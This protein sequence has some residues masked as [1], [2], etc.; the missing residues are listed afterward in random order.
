MLYELHEF[1]QAT[2]APLLVW[3]QA[4]ASLFSSPYS[5]LSYMPASRN[6]AAGYD[7]LFRL[8]KRY[9]KPEF[10]LD[11]TIINGV[12][13]GVTEEVVVSKPFCNLVH[14]KRTIESPDPSVLL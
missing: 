7:L 4:N 2:L 8:G 13:V 12:E 14:F 6:M 9:E 3:A 11:K 10:G 5:A 1:Q